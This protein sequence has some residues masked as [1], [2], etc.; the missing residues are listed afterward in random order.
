[1]E[2]SGFGSG[3]DGFQAGLC[4]RR[5]DGGLGQSGAFSAELVCNRA[6]H[7]GRFLE[8]GFGFGEEGR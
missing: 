6:L 8:N 7:M 3:N 2:K 4:V 1:M 5:M